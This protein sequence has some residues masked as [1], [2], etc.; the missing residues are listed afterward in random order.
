MTGAPFNYEDFA[1]GQRFAS[2]SGRM[3]AAAI[4]EFA[5]EFD[6]QP[7][8]TNEPAAAAGRFGGLIASGWH[9]AAV[10]M[11]LLMTGGLPPVA[12]GTVGAGVE[13]LNWPRPVRPGDVLSVKTE[14]LETRPSR[15][16]PAYGLVRFRAETRNERGETVQE[17][18]STLIVPRRAAG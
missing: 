9:T 5:A 2:P 16:R 7:Q 10:T 13:S 14:I 3:D 18:T 11:R 1:V 8:H 12:G 15:S 4:K 17:M 6:P